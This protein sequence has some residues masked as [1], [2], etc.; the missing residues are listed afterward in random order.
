LFFISVLLVI[1]AF[2][3]SLESTHKV[4]GHKI[5]REKFFPYELMLIDGPVKS[6]EVGY[7]AYSS[8]KDGDSVFVESSR[9]FRSCWK[10]T[11]GDQVIYRYSYGRLVLIIF[12]VM[13]F[14]FARGWNTSDDD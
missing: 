8:V 1:D 2:L 7:K 5:D 4:D 13:A 9:I 14:A 3:P 12:G 10:I 6:C 11:F